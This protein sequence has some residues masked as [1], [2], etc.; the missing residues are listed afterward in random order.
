MSERKLSLVE[1]SMEILNRKAKTWNI[2]TM[3][4]VRGPLREE[5]LRQALNFSQHR[6]PSL[7]LRIVGSLGNL[8][9]ESGIEEIPLRIISAVYELQWQEV[10]HEELNHSIE[11]SKGLMR[12]SLVYISDDLSYLITTVHHA[13]SDA[14]SCVQLHSEI[15]T[16]C[17]K[18][19]SGEPVQPIKLSI[20]PP[21]EEMLP[22]WTKGLR[23][24]I[25]PLFFLFHSSLQKIWNKPKTLSSERHAP[26]ADRRCHIIPVQIDENL[27]RKLITLC[28]QESTSVHS[29]LC[30]AFMLAVYQK[31]ASGNHD[32]VC[33]SCQS[34]VDLRRRLEMKMSKEQMAL[35]A[36]SVH[37]FHTVKVSTSFWELA[38]DIKRQIEVSVENGDIYNS[39]LISKFFA[40]LSL[41]GASQVTPT[42]ALS[43]I[44][45]VD[46]SESYGVLELEEISYVGSNSL[47]GDIF[48]ATVLTFREKIFLNF[49]HVEPSI[50]QDTMHVLIDN[51]KSY[52]MEVCNEKHL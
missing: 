49:V 17:S 7:N 28:K 15:L 46:I 32:N 31:L 26:L 48:G 2:V 41:L 14:L 18:I 40:N 30:A 19:I 22:E 6:H 23:G 21:V 8:Y 45:K 51:V 52:L 12:V 36:S 27:T 39:I 43:N 37:G 11:A 13:I 25:Y 33:M 24:R 34:F 5:V 50:S 44:G 1:Q 10:V 3:S 9:F 20:I 38:H 16:Y 42:I 47:F 29:A 4:R 35:L